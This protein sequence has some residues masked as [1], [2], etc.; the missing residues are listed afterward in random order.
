MKK[1]KNGNMTKT[2]TSYRID[3]RPRLNCEGCFQ[4]VRMNVTTRGQWEDYRCPNC[5]HTKS[6]RTG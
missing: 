1:T 4:L 6:H 5:G 3:Q 2:K